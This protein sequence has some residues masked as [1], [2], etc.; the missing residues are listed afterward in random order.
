MEF[1]CERGKRYKYFLS[2]ADNFVPLHEFE[3]TI[4]EENGRSKMKNLMLHLELLGIEEIVGLFTMSGIVK[5]GNFFYKR[6]VYFCGPFGERAL[7]CF[8]GMGPTPFRP[9]FLGIVC[10]AG[11]PVF[12]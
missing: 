11:F 3:N 7:H 6:P 8:R 5:D 12:L 10:S 9:T 1:I 2:T 4:H